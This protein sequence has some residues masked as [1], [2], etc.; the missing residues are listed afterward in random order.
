MQV[1]HIMKAHARRYCDRLMVNRLCVDNEWNADAVNDMYIEGVEWETIRGIMKEANGVL[2][3]K[4]KRAP[5]TTV[6]GGSWSEQRRRRNGLRDSGSCTACGAEVADEVHRVHECDAMHGQRVQ[7]RAEGRIGRFDHTT[8]GPGLA[9]LICMGL[10]LAVTKWEPI[11]LRFREGYV[12]MGNCSGDSKEVYGDGSGYNQCQVKHR[13]ATWSIARRRGAEAD[14]E[15]GYERLRGVVD[16]WFSTVPR[17][18]LT[19]LIE[20]L[21]HAGSGEAFIGDCAYVVE[22]AR[23]GVPERLAMSRN[24]NADLWREVRRQVKDRGDM[25]EV[26]K[27]RAH[28]SWTAAVQDSDEPMEWWYGNRVV[29]GYAKSLARGIAEADARCKAASE[30]KQ[31]HQTVITRVAVGAA[32]A[33]QH[34][35]DVARVAKN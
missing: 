17:G 2:D 22:G 33:Y 26:H 29:D 11:E 24:V 27:T 1:M 16:G 18:E 10:P 3:A 20:F 31:F 25:P 28:R 30:A 15:H 13:V 6:S 7:W 5:M 8:C 9:P 19:A 21:R 12:G 23:N 34:W 14:D 35:P 4:D 32:W